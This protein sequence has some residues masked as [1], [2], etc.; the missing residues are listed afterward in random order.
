MSDVS[1]TQPVRP[2]ASAAVADPGVVKDDFPDPGVQEPEPGVQDPNGGDVQAPPGDPASSMT[3]PIAPARAVTD[4]MIFTSPADYNE[5]WYL[6]RYRPVVETGAD[7]GQR[8][9]IRLQERAPGWALVIDLETYAAPEL[10]AGGA[11]ILP[12]SSYVVLRYELSG[13]TGIQKE[14]NFELSSTGGGLLTATLQIATIPERDE[15]YWALTTAEAHT[16]LIINRYFV[17]AVPVTSGEPV[18]W[19]GGGG[20]GGE[21]ALRAQ[22]AAQA[23]GPTEVDESD[24]PPIEPVDYIEIKPGDFIDHPLRPIILD[25]TGVARAQLG[26]TTINRADLTQ[27]TISRA[28]LAR[29]SA[30]EAKLAQASVSRAALAEPSVSARNIVQ[31]PP[32]IA[33]PVVQAPVKGQTLY[34]EWEQALADQPAPTPFVFAPDLHGYIFG[35]IKPGGSAGT[36]ERHQLVWDGVHHSYYQEETRRNVFYY[37]PDAFKLSRVVAALRHPFINVTFRSTDDSLATTTATVTFGGAPYVD[38]ERLANAETALAPL[39]GGA[40]PTFEPLLADDERLK[41]RLALPGGG[42]GLAKVVQGAV[43]DLRSK[44]AAAV[45]LSLTDFQAVY[46]ALMGAE[47]GSILFTGEIEVALGDPGKP[48]EKVPFT[49]R[50]DDLIGPMVTWQASPDQPSGGLRV[51][52]TNGIESPVR[53]ASLSSELQRGSVRAPGV[54][55]NLALPVEQLES[56]APLEFVVTSTPPLAGDGALE[57][58]FDLDGVKALPDREAIWATICDP[59][60]AHFVRKVTIKA[61]TGLFDPPAGAPD[62]AVVEVDVE[63]GVGANGLTQTV[64]LTKEAPAKDVLLSFPIADVILGRPDVGAFR[65]QVTAVRAATVNTGPWQTKTGELLWIVS[66]NVKPA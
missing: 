60:T 18:V 39:T 57:V 7:G 30:G 43:I 35:G 54:F 46:D 12:H 44:L 19:F 15:L 4:T 52:L 28:A 59:T 62:Q 55:Q 3:V 50:L 8:Y 24:G 58:D 32:I 51:T 41:F 1:R 64:P 5:K 42:G 22:P 21:A 29:P 31:G 25:E 17:V 66:D 2:M 61:P 53:I 34:A 11:K 56:R 27:A 9:R 47:S 37:L 26:Q 13:G 23:L 65:Y 45:E 38:A 6:P 36:L 20:S 33:K 48:A 14:L 40:Q 16:A 49:G 63:I 10:A